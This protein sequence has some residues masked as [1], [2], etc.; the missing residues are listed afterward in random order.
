MQVESIPKFRR[1]QTRTFRD[2]A[3]EFVLTNCGEGQGAGLTLVASPSRFL[4]PVDES[5]YLA[6]RF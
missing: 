3:N 2:E 4:K 1:P 5:I 6:N